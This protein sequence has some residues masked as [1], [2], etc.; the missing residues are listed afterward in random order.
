VHVFKKFEPTEQL[1]LGSSI[2]FQ[3]FFRRMR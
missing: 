1:F 3:H 2:D